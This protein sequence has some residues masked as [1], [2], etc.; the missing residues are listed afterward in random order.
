[1]RS[2]SKTG[3]GS[4]ERDLVS[5]VAVLNF[6]GMLTKTRKLSITPCFCFIAPDGVGL[7]SRAEGEA[8]HTWNTDT[9]LDIGTSLHGFD[10]MGLSRGSAMGAASHCPDL[11]RNSNQGKPRPLVFLG[12][13]VV[14][15]VDIG[16]PVG[17]AI[18]LP[19]LVSCA[20]RLLI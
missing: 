19:A 9:G 10:D 2:V 11:V 12:C 3:A 13:Y 18:H 4:K 6:F 7:W 20:V 1:M 15:M 5:E 14:C 16:Q 17:P 8:L